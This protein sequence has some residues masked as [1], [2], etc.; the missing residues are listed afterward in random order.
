MRWEAHPL[1]KNPQ[2]SPRLKKSGLLTVDL[3]VTNRPK[4]RLSESRQLP[5]FKEGTCSATLSTKHLIMHLSFINIRNK[6]GTNSGPWGSPLVM[7]DII[8]MRNIIVMRDA[9]EMRD[10]IE[11]CKIRMKA[12]HPFALDKLS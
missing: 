7:R 11:T 2:K 12:F 8:E 3:E 6:V 1:L 4:F 5:G 10:E 9:I